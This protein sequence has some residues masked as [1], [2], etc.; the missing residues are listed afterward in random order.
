MR[1][2][3]KLNKACTYL[4]SLIADGWEYPDAHTKAVNKF[5]VNADQLADLYDQA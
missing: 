2:D 3:S 4:L 5:N 1:N